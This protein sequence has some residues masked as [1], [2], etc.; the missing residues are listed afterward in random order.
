MIKINE[1]KTQTYEVI[2][3]SVDERGHEYYCTY[4]VSH[5]L[6]EAIKACDSLN[7]INQKSDMYFIVE[8][9]LG[10]QEHEWI[11]G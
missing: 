9:Y 7:E 11:Y 5:D 1:E 4:A 10:N 3:C 8:E 6:K 2:E